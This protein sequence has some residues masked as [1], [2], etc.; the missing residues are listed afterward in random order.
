MITKKSKGGRP[1]K[2]NKII[3]SKLEQAAL[4]DCTV[5]EMCFAAGISRDTFYKWI[6]KDKELSDKLEA[7]RNKPILKAR[8]EVIKGLAGNP[9]F[10]LKY[11]ERKKPGEFGSKYTLNIKAVRMVVDQIVAIINKH[12]KDSTVKENIAAD[13][14]KIKF[15]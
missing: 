13:L 9:A 1:T 3:V 14:K 5:S 8:R 6:K 15:R 7:F 11:L 10:S 4:L 12:I 2:L